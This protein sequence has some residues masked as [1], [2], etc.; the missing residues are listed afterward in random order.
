MGEYLGFVLGATE[1]ARF[2][3]NASDFLCL[4]ITLWIENNEQNCFVSVVFSEIQ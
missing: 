4:N 2:K 3:A 1:T